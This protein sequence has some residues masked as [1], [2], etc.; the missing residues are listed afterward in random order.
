MKEREVRGASLF[1]FDFRRPD[2]PHQDSLT[3]SSGR[4]MA[5]M[6]NERTAMIQIC[7]P[8]LRHP[9]GAGDKQ[10]VE[11]LAD[12]DRT[13]RQLGRLADGRNDRFWR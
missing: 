12:E 7:S 11:L 1:S 13:T 8:G 2:I 4:P 9:L 5:P 10:P 6:Q 3:C